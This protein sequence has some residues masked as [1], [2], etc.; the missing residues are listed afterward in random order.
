VSNTS[1]K[2]R[3]GDLVAPTAVRSG[4]ST[5][6]IRWGYCGAHGENMLAAASLQHVKIEHKDR[7]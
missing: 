1:G 7:F 3:G 4:G 5:F 2:H 6:L